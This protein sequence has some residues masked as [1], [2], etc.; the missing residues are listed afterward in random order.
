M[1]ELE[2]AQDR[3]I[4]QLEQQLAALRAEIKYMKSGS[5]DMSAEKAAAL[6]STQQGDTDG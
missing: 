5:K 2:N 1:S 6:R 4:Q 3:K